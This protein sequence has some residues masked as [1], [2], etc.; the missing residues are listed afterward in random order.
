MVWFEVVCLSG[1]DVASFSVLG[2]FIGGEVNVLWAFIMLGLGCG[3]F[4]VLWWW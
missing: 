4:F 1:Y 3:L 2:G